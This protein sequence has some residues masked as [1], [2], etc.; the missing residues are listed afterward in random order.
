MILFIVSWNCLVIVA[1]STSVLV[2]TPEISAEL[3]TTPTI[4]NITNRYAPSN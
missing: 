2:A 3:H 4:I 1:T